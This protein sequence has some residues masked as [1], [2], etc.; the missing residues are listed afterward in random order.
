MHSVQPAERKAVRDDG[1]VGILRPA[2][3]AV[4][5]LDLSE[6]VVSGG[7]APGNLQHERLLTIRMRV[8]EVRAVLDGRSPPNARPALLEALSIAMLKLGDTR[9]CLYMLVKTGSYL[10]WVAEPTS[11][12]LR[13]GA[14]VEPRLE[15]IAEPQ[16]PAGDCVSGPRSFGWPSTVAAS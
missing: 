13:P 15:R 4:V 5:H 12:L 16:D 1:I 10:R 9:P 6:F 14:V 7:S 3:S 11:V 2:R 8:C